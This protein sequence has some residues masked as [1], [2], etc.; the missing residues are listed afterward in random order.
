MTPVFFFHY[1]GTGKTMLTSSKN[2]R[3]WQ[4]VRMVAP[5]VNGVKSTHSELKKT[6]LKKPFSTHEGEVWEPFQYEHSSCYRF[7]DDRT[8]N[9]L[10]VVFL[11]HSETDNNLN[12]HNTDTSLRSAENI[13]IE[14]SNPSKNL[15]A[16]FEAYNPDL[17]LLDEGA[18]LESKAKRQ[19]Y[20]S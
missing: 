9:R 20:N 5:D 14:E 12:P 2:S 10:R 3:A 4:L 15:R 8:L 17:P 11:T 13:P 6:R 16:F 1:T 19:K 7:I 18:L